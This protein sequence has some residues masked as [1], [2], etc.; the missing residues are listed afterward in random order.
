MN[1]KKMTDHTNETLKPAPC[2]PP[3]YGMY[4]PYMEE[5][6][7]NLLDLVKTIWRYKVMLVLLV[8][9]TGVGAVFYSLSLPNIY[10]SEA[11]VSPREE[12]KSSASA[13]SALGGLGGLAGDVLGFGGGGSLAKFE[14]VLRS[15]L[16]SKTI[17]DK[18]RN[19]VLSALYPDD[20]D[21]D[22]NKW[23]PEVEEPPSEQDVIKALLEALSVDVPRD[24]NVMTVAFEHKDPEFAKNIV[25][26]Y[27][28]ELS[29][30][31]RQA[32]LIDAAENQKFLQAQVDMI[33][34][35]LLKEK[36]YALLAKEIE[37]QTF[38]KAQ[39]P[40]AFVVLDPPIV[41]DLDKKV[42]PKRSMICILSVTV[43]GF[44]GIFL[45]FF[46][47]FIKKA[48]NESKETANQSAKD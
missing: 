28:E 45:V 27:L 46:I 35:V 44:L 37:K 13:L 30:S 19:Q 1:E 20:W 25:E 31:L 43:A 47:E 16:L 22:Q 11:S 2:P 38:A 29:E 36:V 23:Q 41:P 5:D 26:Y 15:R 3:P 4:Q 12:E 14:T 32:T 33:S 40:Y 17:F 9:L 34:D 42:K 10:R 48:R 18:H 7:I 6:E 21:S 24:K 8:F 39:V